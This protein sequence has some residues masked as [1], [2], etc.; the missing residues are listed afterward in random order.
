MP[1]N[2]PALDDGL[3]SE[4][5][6]GRVFG[7]CVTPVSPKLAITYRHRSHLK[8]KLHSEEK[9]DKNSIVIIRNVVNR[10]VH[11]K[12]KVPSLPVIPIM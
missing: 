12:M 5:F 1:K 11:Y 3:Q 10:D 8:L 9:E 2:Q 4:I 7:G 6:D